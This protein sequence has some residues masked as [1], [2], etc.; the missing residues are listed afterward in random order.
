MTK[1][2]S[3]GK[4]IN[5]FE[6]WV[7][8]YL[9]YDWDNVGLQVG[10]LS[11]PVQKVMTT[12][13]VTESVVDEAIEKEID[14]IIAHHP[15]LFKSLKQIDLSTPKGRIVQKLLTHDITVYAAHTNLDIVPGGVNDMLSDQLNLQHTSVLIPERK[16]SLYKLCIYVPV[17]ALET[18]DQALVEEGI[19]QLGNYKDCSYR[20]NGTGTF[21]PMDESNPY[22]GEK[23]ERSFVDEVKIEYAVEQNQIKTALQ[24]L[25][26]NHPY[27]EPAYDLIK[28]EN[29]AMTYGLGR[30]GEL[31]EPTSLK[32]FCSY[33][34]TQFGLNGLRVTGDLDQKVSKVAILGG[35]GEG[36]FTQAKRLGAD[37]YIT[38]D[39]TFHPA[40]DAEAIGLSIID[41]GHYVEKTMIS[42]VKDYLTK[43]VEENNLN[44]NV[45]K[46]E[47][48]TDPFRFI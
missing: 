44:I 28:L 35:S 24:I 2:V 11:Q 9:A 1:H 30:I 48:N 33:V 13:D 4:V 6:Q 27:E 8:K 12:L 14:L 43:K 32:D 21:T 31:S 39:M 3:A 26:T 10:Q 38:G 41:V 34:K 5:L 46:S 40:Q 29:E 23:E 36:F 45:I 7:P 22:I 42:G 19:G 16:E 20:I 17:N 37:V 15:L 25:H 47:V 18:V